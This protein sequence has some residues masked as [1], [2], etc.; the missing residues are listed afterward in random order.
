MYHY[1]HVIKFARFNNFCMPRGPILGR[2]HGLPWPPNGSL[3]VH[4]SHLTTF[5]F[6]FLYYINIYIFTYITNGS[7]NFHLDSWHSME[8]SKNRAS[9]NWTVFCITECFLFQGIRS[10]G[11][12]CVCIYVIYTYII[13]FGKTFSLTLCPTGVFCTPN[14]GDR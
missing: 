10:T 5:I 11:T 8:K 9:V 6:R 2:I 7:L 4:G 1:I 3:N 12:P 14:H 13:I